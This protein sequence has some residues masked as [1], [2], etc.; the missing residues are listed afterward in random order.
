MDGVQDLKKFFWKRNFFVF[1]LVLMVSV[2]FHVNCLSGTELDL[3]Q[4]SL[5][6]LMDIKV[7]S[8][9]K[10]S[11]NLSDSAAAI[12]VITNNDLKR[13]GVTNIPDALRMVPGLTVARID[14]NKWAVNARGFN[15]RFAAQ[16]LVLIDGRS[17]YTPTFSGVYWEVNDVLLEDVD[18]I[19]VIRGPG[20]TLWGANAVNGVIN[21]ITKH[22]RDTQGGVV[23]VGGGDFERVMT[24]ARYGG[25]FGEDSHWRL[26]AKHQERDTFDYATGGDAGDDWKMTQSGFRMDSTLSPKN[27]ITVQGD[28][29][30]G[31]IN[32]DLNL[33][34]KQNFPYMG[35]FPVETSVS[36]GNLLSRWQHTVSSNSDFALQV[37]YDTTKRTEDIIDEER[38]N[39]DV[40]LQHRFAAGTRHDI[41]WGARYRYTKDDYINSSISD[42]DPLSRQD[43]LY[44]TFVQDEI[45]FLENQVRLTLGSKFEHNDYSGFE[46]QPSARL[47]WAVNSENKIWGAVSRAVRTPSRGE[48]DA[49]FSNLASPSPIPGVPVVVEFVGNENF[50]SEELVAYELGYRFIPAREFSVDVTL[51]YNEYDKL[52]QVEPQQS[53]FMGTSI[54]QVLLLGNGLSQT[55]SGGELA[56]SFRPW[57]FF[58]CDLAY[59]Y[60]KAHKDG[61]G[62][63]PEHQASVRGQFNLSKTIDLDI[64][65]RYVDETAAS[66]LLADNFKYEIDDYFTMDLRLGWRITPRI[67]VSLVGQNLLD[68]SHV[69]FVQETFGQ[70][71]EV[72]RSFYAKLSYRF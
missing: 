34:D 38:D 30:Q 72:E 66:Y 23:S 63:F 53:N 65:L 5:E 46:V 10:K 36:G 52:R 70:V 14:A 1:L 61:V 26:Y 8:V 55:T 57:D 24:A 31:D 28:I 58:K 11:Q 64:W 56:A 35:V 44:S 48:T 62:G 43:N 21:I 18:R 29:Y 4:L 12:F 41:L 17:V 16:L 51:F 33:V 15:S 68:K 32:Q 9:S 2:S 19:E 67:E 39:I 45:S 7:T 13:S 69:E 25:S 59:S 3:T 22:T 71:T 40:D 6:E 60:V 47:M 50:E 20:A 49:V 54:E 27:R 42:M 37:Y